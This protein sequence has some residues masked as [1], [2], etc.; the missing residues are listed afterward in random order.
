MGRGRPRAESVLSEYFSNIDPFLVKDAD[1]LRKTLLKVID[2]YLE[3]FPGTP[4]KAFSRNRVFFYF[5]EGILLVFPAGVRAN[6]LAEFLIAIKY[7]DP[8]SI[9]YHFYEARVGLQEAGQ[10]IFSK[11]VENALGR[12]DLATRIRNIDPV[13]HTLEGIREHIVEAVEEEVKKD[14]E[15]M[16]A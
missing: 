14:M 12:K 3:E 13:M 6:N 11:W 5:N 4:R 10:M 1:D 15:V 16:P 7:I 2:G 9:Y 8:P